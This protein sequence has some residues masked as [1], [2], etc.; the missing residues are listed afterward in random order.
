MGLDMYLQGEKY[1]CTDWKN[2][3]NNLCEDGYEVRSKI[4][5]EGLTTAKQ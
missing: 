4:L 2:P 5:P 1:L 3:Q